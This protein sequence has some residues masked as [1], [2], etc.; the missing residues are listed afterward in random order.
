MRISGWGSEVWSSDLL[1][2]GARA[3]GA[4]YGRT[5]VMVAGWG[6]GGLLRG[7]RRHRIDLGRLDRAAARERSPRSA[8]AARAAVESANPRVPPWRCRGMVARRH[9]RKSVR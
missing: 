8:R 2:A 9:A 4:R 3:P 7:A 5:S 6:A 1:E